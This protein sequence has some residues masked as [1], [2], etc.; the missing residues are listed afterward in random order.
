MATRGGAQA[1]SLADTGMLRTG[2]KADLSVFD[3]RG[4]VFATHEDPLAS[5]VFSSFDHRARWVMVGGRLIVDDGVI[6]T[7]DESAILAEAAEV[8]RYLL[9]RNSEYGELAGA[10]EAFLTR[11]SADAAPPR[12]VMPFRRTS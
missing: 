9:R 6:Q 4:S 5:L 1:L 3:L 10:Q 11:V 2:M 12:E 7:V 8:S